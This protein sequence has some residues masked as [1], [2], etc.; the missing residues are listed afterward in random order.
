MKFIILHYPILDSTNNLAKEFASLGVRG[1]TVIFSDYQRKGRGRFKR[2]WISPKGK[3]LLFSV[4]LRPTHVKAN[5]V[6]IVT[7]TTAMSIRDVL[8]QK[9]DISAKIK[10]PNDLLVNGKKIC[11][12]LVESSTHKNMIE[13]IVVGIGLNVNSRQR[14]LLRSATSLREMLGEQKDR[15]QLLQDLLGGFLKQMTELGW[16][17]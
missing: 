8:K 13:Y 5:A 14:E 9:F 1:G 7:Q 16:F 4:I 2:K 11:G 12:I 3:D 6:S 17:S 15:K 10:R